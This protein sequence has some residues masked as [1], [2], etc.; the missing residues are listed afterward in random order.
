MC[1]SF[2]AVGH[3]VIGTDADRDKIEGLLA[4]DMPFHEPELADCIRDGMAR[5]RL[6]FVH[7][8]G[9]AVAD[10]DVVFVCVGTPPRATGEANLVA[11]ERA[12]REV[13]RS[14][15]PGL[16]IADKS[17]VPAGTADRLIRVIEFQHP[18]L[19]GAVEVVSN[20]EFLREGHALSHDRDAS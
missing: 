11:V 4:A 14:A 8:T 12:V 6:T 2:A 15:R 10:A 5:G 3:D 7:D 9:R 1:A 13:V 20:P 17:T 18:D 16:V 19:A